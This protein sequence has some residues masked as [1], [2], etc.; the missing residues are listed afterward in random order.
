M[1]ILKFAVFSS[2]LFSLMLKEGK[3]FRRYSV[4]SIFIYFS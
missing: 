2:M 4:L 3:N 1:K